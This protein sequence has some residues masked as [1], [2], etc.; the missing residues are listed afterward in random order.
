VSRPW[1]RPQRS[2][3]LFPS[4]KR[5]RERALPGSFTC[6]S[7]SQSAATPADP[8][9][10]PAR[11]LRPVGPSRAPPSGHTPA[12]GDGGAPSGSAAVRPFA[13]AAPLPLAPCPAPAGSSP[14]CTARTRSWGCGGRLRAA[15][16]RQHLPVPASAAGSLAR[17]ATARFAAFEAWFS[18]HWCLLRRAV[19][20]V[21]EAALGRLSGPS[22]SFVAAGP[23]Q[24]SALAVSAVSAPSVQLPDGL[25]YAIGASPLA[26]LPGGLPCA[27]ASAPRARLPH[28]LLCVIEAVPRAWLPDGLSCATE[29]AT[30]GAP[31][32]GEARL[33]WVIV[34]PGPGAPAGVQ[35]PTALSPPAPAWR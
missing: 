29:A 23:L 32:S 6:V 8:G 18:S 7:L 4:S 34:R 5:T 33:E 2:R 17:P 24:S 10:A 35:P 30:G 11:G 28:G 25:P 20:D 14:G 1:G 27:I 21:S 3:C 26:R 12:P 16:A 31:T 13:G 22:G 9:A 19:C 15:A